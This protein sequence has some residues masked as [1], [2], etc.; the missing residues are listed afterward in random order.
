MPLEMDIGEKLAGGHVK[1][2][3]LRAR[4]DWMRENRTPRDVAV[5]TESLS[6]KL[7]EKL[8]NIAPDAWHPFSDL[9][10]LDKAIVNT[11]GG[12][13]VSVLRQIGRYSARKNLTQYNALTKENVPDFFRN[14]ARVHSQF[15]NF[16]TVIYRQEGE[17]KAK[18]VHANYMSYSPLFCESAIGYYEE[19]LLLHKARKPVITESQCQCKGA[20]T[21]TF[22]MSWS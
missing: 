21:C 13:D 7:R 9:V 22:E 19:C 8:A 12:G 18:M 11:L 14:A 5:F 16:G 10:E 20:P 4:I 17:G 2:G 3:L 1:G 15:Q 6:P